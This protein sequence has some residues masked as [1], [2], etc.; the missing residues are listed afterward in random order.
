MGVVLAGLAARQWDK[1]FNLTRA[2]G[3]LGESAVLSL[4]FYVVL[5]AIP[6]YLVARRVQRTVS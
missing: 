5:L 2:V 3:A 6:L 4:V 1:G